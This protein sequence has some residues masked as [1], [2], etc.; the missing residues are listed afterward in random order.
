MNGALGSVASSFSN[1]QGQCVFGG[2]GGEPGMLDIPFL[3]RVVKLEE[4]VLLH[5]IHGLFLPL[6]CNTVC[7]TSIFSMAEKSGGKALYG[8]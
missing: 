2:Y 6:Q 3:E 8:P 7:G 5:A 1:F 4:R